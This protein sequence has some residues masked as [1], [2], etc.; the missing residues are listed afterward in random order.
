[1]SAKETQSS[2]TAAL[3]GAREGRAVLVIDHFENPTRGE[4]CVAAALTTPEHVSFMAVHARGLVCLVTVPTVLQRLGVPLIPPDRTTENALAYGVSFEAKCGVSTGISAADRAETIRIAIDPAAGPADIV[5]PG[6]IPPIQVQAGGVMEN[7]GQMEAALDLVRLAEIGDAATVCTVLD[8][9]GEIAAGPKLFEFAQ[10]H[11]LAVASMD[12]VLQHR[13]RAE[14]LVERLE[15]TELESPHGGSFRGIAYRNKVDET[16]H[17]ALVRGKISSTEPT[18][19][20]VHSQCLTGDVLGS[21]RCDC[22]EQLTAS[23]RMIAEVGDGVLVYLH[24]EG[25]GIGLA[26]KIRAYALQD[27]GLDT[28]EA[29][30]KLGFE[31]DQRDYGISAQILRDLGVERVRLMTNNQ[32]KIDGLL[33]YGIEV[34]ERVALQIE[35]HE[36]N[37]DYLRAKREKLGHLLTGLG[38]S[39]RDKA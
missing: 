6:H 28:V 17:L 11:G 23:L 15:E 25:R 10:R 22:G 19:V 8:E 21:R 20:R 39:T 4:V 7:P 36:G 33:R 12:A 13:L 3:N 1:M 31:D 34:A 26:N 5:M 2:L 16:E 35:P 38:G 27:G 30:L 9:D 32:R 37:I 14:L 24:Q 18:L 29:N